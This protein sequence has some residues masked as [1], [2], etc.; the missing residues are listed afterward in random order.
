MMA[1]ADLPSRTEHSSQRSSHGK[2]PGA[3]RGRMSVTSASAPLPDWYAPPPSW[4]RDIDA[5]SAASAPKGWRGPLRRLEDALQS[6]IERRDKVR[7]RALDQA[8]VNQKNFAQREADRAYALAQEALDLAETLA[9][10]VSNAETK[11]Q[12]RP[13]AQSY[14]LAVDTQARPGSP[15]LGMHFDDLTSDEKNRMAELIL[16]QLLE[17]RNTALVERVVSTIDM[18]AFANQVG[19][20]INLELFNDRIDARIRAANFQEMATAQGERLQQLEREFSDKTGA[21]PMLRAELRSLEARGNTGSL[22]RAGYVSTGLEDVQAFV[23]LAG[24][25][26]LSTLCLDLIGLLTLA[27]DPFVTYEAGVKVHADAIKANFSSVLESRIKMSF[28]VPFPEVLVRHVE[29]STTAV[30]GGCK[31][32]PLMA[33]AKLFEDDFRDG[34][35]RRM[36]KGVENAYELTRKAI[37]TAFPVGFSGVR[38]QDNCKVHAIL[39]AQLQMAYHQTIGYIECLLP[40]YRTLKGSSLSDAEA[41]NR[42]FVFNLEFLTSLQEERITTTDMS[43][44]A[45]M[46]HGC[47]KATDLAEEFRRQKFIE[48]PKALSILALTSMEREGKTKALLEDHIDKKIA[49]ATK[50]GDKFTKLD[51]RIQT[52][53]NKF[54]NLSPRIQT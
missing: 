44:E 41:W 33:S 51:T 22:D 19:R 7:D 2:Q 49:E 18:D 26:K 27:Q 8:F 30:N 45:A 17:S 53:E 37:D 48:H 5:R 3:F 42:V 9:D 43:N 28:E 10:R 50:G 14:R 25:G 52:M 11:L 39:T 21:I 29:S 34:T 32:S 47:F 46:I 24:P 31:W 1:F 12:G 38:S 35:H 20:R 6:E 23:L 13:G 54:K 36:L 16:S 15:S 4:Y 40:F